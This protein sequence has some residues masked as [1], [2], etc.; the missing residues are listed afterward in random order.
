MV[1]SLVASNNKLI[2]Q[3]T[4][5]KE[6]LKNIS[7]ANQIHKNL[8]TSLIA[9]NNELKTKIA[10]YQDDINKSSQDI[11]MDIDT[12]HFDSQS[13][14]SYHTNLQRN[15]ASINNLRV[16]AINR[17]IPFQRVENPYKNDPFIGFY[18]SNGI[19]NGRSVY[20]GPRDGIYYINK[21]GRIDYVKTELKI[22]N[23]IRV[24]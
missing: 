11:D 1:N 16:N 5:D 8:A 18:T 23:V 2:S 20:E 4:A 21:C 3:I 22:T 15:T 12:N 13:T 17:H 7:Q 9:S 14:A 6:E 10:R 24:N 19:N